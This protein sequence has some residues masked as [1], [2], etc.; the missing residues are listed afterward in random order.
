M[1]MQRVESSNIESVGYDPETQQLQVRFTNGSLYQYD[2]VPA[3]VHQD[4]MG[5]DSIGTQ[6]HQAVKGTYPHTRLE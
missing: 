5:S 1:D 2:D 6:L 3:E 4:L